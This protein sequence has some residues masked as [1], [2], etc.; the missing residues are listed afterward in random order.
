MYPLRH[1]SFAAV[2]C[3]SLWKV[4]D[5]ATALLMERFYQNVLGK[6]FGLSRRMGKAGALAEAKRWLRNLSADEV[7][8]LIAD[9]I[10]DV[11]RAKGEKALNTV[12]GSSTAL[13]ADE[14]PFAHPRYWAAF[15]L[16]GDP[17]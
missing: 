5:T 3:L 13:A 9:F 14:H 12:D 2:Y 11:V 4:D 15:I 17:E 8:T 10:H 1:P 7:S 6:R 16:I